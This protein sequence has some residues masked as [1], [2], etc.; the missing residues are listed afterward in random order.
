MEPDPARRDRPAVLA[1]VIAGKAR[2]MGGAPGAGWEDDRAEQ[3]G[4]HGA[5]ADDLAGGPG[6]TLRPTRSDRSLR[7]GRSLRPGRSGL[8]GRPGRTG[9]TLWPRRTLRARHGRR[10]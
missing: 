6:R 4:G 5:V 8:T 7:A 10:S 1:D 2:G 3:L 9:L